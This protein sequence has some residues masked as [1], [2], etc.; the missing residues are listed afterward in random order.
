[1]GT[2]V[3][4]LFWRRSKK[5]SPSNMK[6]TLAVLLVTLYVVFAMEKRHIFER[7]SS[8]RECGPG[9]CC[10]SYKIYNFCAD[11]LDEGDI[12]T[13]WSKLSC[14]CKDGLE[15]KNVNYFIKRCVKESGSG[16]AELDFLTVRLMKTKWLNF[17]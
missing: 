7:C 11:Q 8:N 1:M 4:N 9:R 14:G 15:C 6:I 5:L 12:C 17:S 10:V 16:D 3:S 2:P 13:V